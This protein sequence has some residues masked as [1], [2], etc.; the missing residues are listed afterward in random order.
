MLQDKWIQ[1]S[2]RFFVFLFAWTFLLPAQA[3]DASVYKSRRQK[4]MEQLGDGAAIIR[5]TSSQTRNGDETYEYRTGSDFYYLTGFEYPDAALL[6]IP[7]GAKEAIFFVQP[8]NVFS[9][10]WFGDIPG[11]EGAMK[12]YG[13]DTAFSDDQLAKMLPVLLRE[14]KTLYIDMNDDRIRKTVFEPPA[15]TFPLFPEVLKDISPLVHELRVVKSEDELLLLGKAIDITG[16]ALSE[17]MMQAAPGMMEYEAEAILEYIYARNGCRRNGFASIIASGPNATV[18]HYS[19]N[20]RRMQEGDLLV[21]DVGAE[22]GYYTA[23]ITRT[24][25]V[26]GTYSAAQ[27]EIYELVLAAQAAAIGEMKPGMP[28]QAC[29][30]RAAET[31][32]QGLYR[33][34]LI[35]DVKS[36]WQHLAYYYPYISHPIGLDVHDVGDFRGSGGGRPLEAGMVLTIEPG[37]YFSDAMLDV[38]KATVGAQNP[39]ETADFLEKVRP[40]YEKYRN[41]GVRIEDDILITEQGNR[42]LSVQAPR[43]VK[44]IESLMRRKSVFRF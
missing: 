26:S 20:S 16:E 30:Q 31:I 7:G 18:L 2:I 42:V 33:L 23:D 10:L 32:K 25:P 19:A 5:N 3:Q 12:E 38:F 28:A 36:R 34:G 44:E 35:T 43:S 27:K 8:E 6:L 13:A 41:I 39:Q 9:P 40:A 29:A 24:I 22:Y 4:L 14:K 15:G 1:R 11:I 17:V 21:M 37:L